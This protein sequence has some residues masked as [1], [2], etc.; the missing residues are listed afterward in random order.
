MW[1]IGS[2]WDINEEQG[3]PI[4]KPRSL[5]GL[6][7]LSMEPVLSLN[8]PIACAVVKSDYPALPVGYSPIVF[9]NDY[10]DSVMLKLT[11]THLKFKKMKR[12]VF[13]FCILTMDFTTAFY[14]DIFFVYIYTIIFLGFTWLCY[15][16]N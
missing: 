10:H 16:S 7:V 5:R 9:E 13:N 6:E 15:F 4:P 8:G 1:V 2:F 14:L 12:S 11:S 3:V